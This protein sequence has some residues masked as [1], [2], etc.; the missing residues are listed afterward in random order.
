M[1]NLTAKQI[2]KLNYMNPTAKDAKLGTII[3]ALQST[4]TGTLITDISGDITINSSKASLI[5]NGAVSYGKLDTNTKQFYIKERIGADALAADTS[6]R[7]ILVCNTAFTV[8]SV[9]FIPDAGFG[10]ASNYS[11]I[12][13]VNKGTNGSGTTAVAAKAFSTVVTAYT[14]NDFGTVTAPN[15][16]A[17]QV[18]TVKIT[19]TG[20]GQVTPAGSIV[21]V[22]QRAA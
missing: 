3:G 1:T 10:Q 22:A 6:E 19:K 11:N 20:T 17:G 2:D 18:L 21:I 14:N 8:I 16:T 7:S 5:S 12:S 15:V 13:V 4:L 9:G